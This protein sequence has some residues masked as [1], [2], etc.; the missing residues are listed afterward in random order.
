MASSQGSRAQRVAQ[1]MEDI[2]GTP[3]PAA[4]PQQPTDMDG[5]VDDSVDADAT[6]SRKTGWVKQLQEIHVHT[7]VSAWQLGVIDAT[8]LP[9]AP[10]GVYACDKV[11][12]IPYVYIESEWYFD[13]SRLLKFLSAE[14]V[15]IFELLM[16]IP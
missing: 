14:K 6:S 3:S 8:E 9:N 5:F 11:L 12:Y 7:F 1:Q 4:T 13:I 16:C 2:F 10:N 15:S